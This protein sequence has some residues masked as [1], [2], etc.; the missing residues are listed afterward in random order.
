VTATVH[1]LVAVAASFAGTAVVLAVLGRRVWALDG[2]VPVVVAAGSAALAAALSADTAA[3]G[4]PV[5]DVLGRAAI[6]AVAAWAGASAPVAVLVVAAAAVA[7]GSPWVGGSA[8]GGAMAAVATG[9]APRGLRA[10]VGGAIAV[11][12]LHMSWPDEPGARA[13]LAAGAVALVLAGGLRGRRVVMAGAAVV[14]LLGAGAA[15]ALVSALGAKAAVD[16]GVRQVRAGLSSAASGEAASASENLRA[17][18]VHFDA[19]RAKADAWWA[20]PGRAVPVVGRQLQAVSAM[21]SVGADVAADGSRLAQAADPALLT[22]TGGRLP[23]DAMRALQQPADDAVST[24]RHASERLAEVDSPWLLPVVSKP[25]DQLADRL[26]RAEE[27]ASSV[28]TATR[29][30][31]ALLGADGPRRYFLAV[32]TPSELRGSGGFIGNFGEI[33]AADGRMSLTRLGRTADLNDGGDIRTKRVERPADYVRRYARFEPHRFWQNV[34]VSP[35]FPSDGQVIADLY[36]QSGGAPVD[37]VIAVDPNGLAAL[38]QVVGPVTVPDWPEPI[39]AANAARV[40]LFEQYRLAKPTRIDFL[41]AVT[42]QVWERLL[43]GDRRLTD[44]AKAVGPAVSGKH[45][46]LY[47]TRADEQTGLVHLGAAGAMTPTPA[48]Q[49]FLALVTQNAG[50]N[51]IDWFLRR[52]IDADVRVDDRTGAVRSTVRV[53]LRN[54]APAR[55]LPSGV[56]GNIVTPPLPDGT[57][58]LYL[59]VY[60]PLLLEGATLDGAAAPME[61]EQE[62]GRHVYSMFVVIPPGATATL[63][64]RLHG[65]VDP[66]AD[67]PYV[68][69]LF[70]QAAAADDEVT[71]TLGPT[72]RRVTL[73]RDQRVVLP[74]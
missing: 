53:T 70:R 2:L 25:L 44:V 24:L 60:S 72:T 43:S 5:A 57:N 42:M 10:A 39:T 15:V 8:G 28:A 62:L 74:R 7:L 26:A 23:V 38:L 18:A 61:S 1:L 69:N 46:L 54:E 58:K 66:D 71:V 11:A 56:I 33:A 12:A 67:G 6:A 36:P 14:V 32:Q 49:D 52:S 65:T 4:L 41:E 34:T 47:S 29:I 63:E 19:A 35:D 55:G 48:G 45:I 27:Q 31:P 21:A 13:A 50:G 16:D 40:L 73:G 3:T 51:K 22:M 37:G 20:Q 64:L 9:D 68:M 17:A 59:S 30:G